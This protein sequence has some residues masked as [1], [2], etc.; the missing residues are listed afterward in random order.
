M[1]AAARSVVFLG[2]LFRSHWV[3]AA[4]E[5]EANNDQGCRLNCDREGDLVGDP[6]DCSIYY[7]CESKGLVGPLLCP[8]DRPYFNGMTCAEDPIRCCSHPCAPL[9]R[10]EGTQVADPKNCCMYYICAGEGEPSSELHFQCSSGKVFDATTGR[11]VVGTECT[12][13]CGVEAEEALDAAVQ[14][15]LEASD[16]SLEDSRG[17]ERVLVEAW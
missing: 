14:Q 13:S 4:I 6:F 2:L 5:S 10:I 1:D 12:N 11:C 8:G 7:K 9:C 15:R 3:I 17:E 16:A